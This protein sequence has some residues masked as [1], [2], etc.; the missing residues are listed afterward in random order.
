M[1]VLVWA[2]APVPAFHPTRKEVREG[3]QTLTRD[4]RI[5]CETDPR[6]HPFHCHHE[7]TVIVDGELAFVGGIDMTDY[8]GDR[9]DTSDHPARRRLGW[10]D[11]GTRLRGPA[12]ADVDD[13]F[14]LRWRELTG[15][16][17]DRPPAPAHA[18]EH[19]VQVVRTIANGHVRRGPGRR[20]PDPRELRSR[21]RPRR[22]LHLP[23]E[24]VPVV[25]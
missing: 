16:Q 10:H 5:R 11:V 13:H 2:G 6:E 1:R 21:D 24:P 20:V 14:A 22:A 8:A 7:K 17:L 12:V 25:A 18:G 4:T 23:R 19:T 3:V 15:E 9:F